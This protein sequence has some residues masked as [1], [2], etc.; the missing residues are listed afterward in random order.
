MSCQLLDLLDG[1]DKRA[2]EAIAVVTTHFVEVGLDLGGHPPSHH[3][4]TSMESRAVGE[5]EPGAQAAQWKL[6]RA[7]LL[8]RSADMRFSVRVRRDWQRGDGKRQQPSRGIGG[9]LRLREQH[10]RCPSAASSPC[11]P[12]LPTT[13]FL[14]GCATALT[15]AIRDKLAQQMDDAANE[16]YPIAVL[17]IVAVAEEW[18]D[19]QGSEHF[20]A[21]QLEG[22]APLVLRPIIEAAAR[23]HLAGGG[24]LC[25]PTFGLVQTASVV[26]Y[27]NPVQGMLTALRWRTA[28]ARGQA[29]GPRDPAQWLQATERLCSRIHGGLP[30]LLR[31]LATAPTV[32]ATTA[33]DWR[34]GQN[35][36]CSSPRIELYPHFL[37]PCE[38]EHLLGTALARAE[39]PSHAERLDV[40]PKWRAD[41]PS[42]SALARRLE[43]RC[44]LATGVPV[45]ADEA[46]L[47]LKFTPEESLAPPGPQ[48]L[49]ESHAPLELTPV[50]MAV[51]EG[52][53][54][55][56]DAATETPPAGSAHGAVTEP[57]KPASEWL[58]PG[59]ARTP[60]VPSLHVDTHNGGVHRCAT[61]IMYLND[62]PREAGGETRFPIANAQR[63]SALRAA[64]ET[65]IAAGATALYMQTSEAGATLLAAAERSDVGLHVRPAAGSALVFWTT[66]H[67]GRVDPS[68]WHNG[69]RVRQG[70]GGKWIAQKFKEVPLAQR[71]RSQPAAGPAASSAAPPTGAA[72][73]HASPSHRLGGPCDGA[74][75]P[76]ETQQPPLQG[77][78][79][80]L[81][82]SRLTHLH[83]CLAAEADS[84]ASLALMAVSDRVALLARLKAA[85]VTRLPE[86]QA[87]A[88]ALVRTGKALGLSPRKFGAPQP[89]HAPRSPPIIG[90][91]CSKMESAT[92]LGSA[93]TVLPL[94]ESKAVR[95]AE[96]DHPATCT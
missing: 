60:M 29:R 37:S 2:L 86:R 16:L 23:D 65:A 89:S 69:A 66:D 8:E 32:A 46:P 39:L 96:P 74:D 72:P 92:L 42:T 43:E 62:L 3:A 25:R 1:N 95:N 10:S 68:S 53:P 71:P 90:T 6:L 75:W 63:D 88:N 4:H 83:A 44:A 11:R 36:L 5:V 77:W 70:A 48:L 56:G 12:V 38:V 52:L 91:A 67:E 18:A 40:A 61:V 51:S 64:G 57:P 79:T 15:G 82:A 21:L 93:G 94:T 19:N 78:E 59:G 34:A 24:T 20:A 9:R 49:D 35:L 54:V 85:G 22:F 17:S 30:R 13:E 41:L 87:L 73:S 80:F 47:S 45:H 7:Q 50:C 33:H 58:A 28:L 14:V 81:V 27:T 55:A 76:G 31:T 84:P 26:W